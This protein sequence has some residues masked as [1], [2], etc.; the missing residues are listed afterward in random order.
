MPTRPPYIA[1]EGAE[2]TGK[3][4]QARLLAGALGALL[5][6]ET[7]G[8]AIGQRLRAILHDTDVDNLDR[9]AEALIVAADRAQHLAEVVIPALDAGRVVVSDRSVY[10]TL[11]Y[12]GYGRQLDLDEVRHINEWAVQGHWPSLVVYVEAPPALVAERL[13]RRQLDRFEQAGDDFH[14]RVLDGFRAMAAA[15][16]DRWIVVST[17]RTTARGRGRGARRRHRPPPRVGDA[18]ASVTMTVWDA[19]IG[20]PVAVAAL[21]RAARAPVHAYLF[22]GPPGSTK[23]EAARAFAAVLL[24]GREDGEGRDSRLVL[25]GEHPDVREV[26]RV[27][28]AISAEQAAE[29]VRQ[30]ALAPV[31]GERKVLVLHEFHLLNAAGAGRLLKTIE[32]PPPSTHFVILADFVPNDLVTIASRCVRIEFSPITDATVVASLVEAGT[33]HER[34]AE[35]AAVAGGDLDRARLLAADPDFVERHHAFA[36]VPS[37]LDGTGSTVIRLVADLLGRIEAAAEPLA[38]RQAA[39]L[40]EL[41]DRERQIGKR[42][43]G[44]AG[45]EARH[46]RELRRHRTDEI[47]SGLSVIA[48]VYRDAL[49]ARAGHPART[50]RRPPGQRRHSSRPFT[51]SIDTIETLEHNPN[52]TLMLQ[53]LLWSLPTL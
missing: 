35:I 30:A 38:A 32:E 44:R 22:V 45:I 21:A 6:Q 7:G 47:R 40:V 24:T 15:D 13:D 33:E 43:S 34:A 19:V 29:I 20:Q 23:D 2:G 31:E 18:R 49:V 28:P 26:V 50:T 16:P 4:T 8:T 53:S 41:D 39:E 10:S 14:R 3:T 11:A 25:A 5:T 46:K 37:R 1:F 36:V 51:A 17:D 48:G 42:G 27:G 52:E 12:Q 9:R